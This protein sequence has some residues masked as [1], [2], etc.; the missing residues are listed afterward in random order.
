[1]DTHSL[2][3]DI[4]S[5][6]EK[7]AEYGEV[8][9][10]SKKDY[11][12]AK[13]IRD[14]LRDQGLNARLIPLQVMEWIPGRG[15]IDIGG[16]EIDLTIQ[17][18]VQNAYVEAP[19]VY[20]D[21][22]NVDKSCATIEDSIIITDLPPDVDDINTA[23][24]HLSECGALG[25]IFIDRMEC[26]RRIVCTGIWSPLKGVGKPPSI[27]VLQVPKSKGKE[28][29]RYWGSKT[30]LV[31]EGCKTGESTGYIV[32]AEIPS[33]Y[34]DSECIL[35]TSHHDHWLSGIAD[36][37]VGV[38]MT[39]SISK[40]LITRSQTPKHCVKIVIFTAEE[41]GAPNYSSW[42][43]IY[44]S[45]KYAEENYSYIG[46]VINFD[47]IARGDRVTISATPD[48]AHLM[49]IKAAN[50]GI[51]VNTE[52]DQ[53][54]FDSFSFTMHGISAATLNTFH[55]FLSSGIYHSSLDTIDILNRDTVIKA[56][57]LCISTVEQLALSNDIYGV[58]NPKKWS[59]YVLE[60]LHKVNAPLELI[61]SLYR[62]HRYLEIAKESE[63]IKALMHSLI[64]E[65]IKPIMWNGYRHLG[66]REEILIAPWIIASMKNMW[67]EVVFEG[68]VEPPANIDPK[69]YAA[70]KS[71]I[72][73]KRINEFIE[74]SLLKSSRK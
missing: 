69:K 31:V 24:L 49:S 16:K 52:F 23:Q 28:I 61:D 7:L 40:L 41:S 66:N 59:E 74:R 8:I 33:R 57:A 71:Q 70:L 34:E 15:I 13:T 53:P 27:P 50:L 48:L 12:I 3:K 32:E 20:I 11:E 62:V 35:I 1:M 65:L 67:Y 43:W 30:Y 55:E 9:A 22:N 14:D 42:Y 37:L 38:S 72:V 68:L 6:V 4:I 36:N 58:L 25:V 10:G 5:Y 2:W 45:R 54:I 47:T 29:L 63:D 26:R 73:A 64:S 51:E 18:Y 39:M 56:V 17:P 46:A 44:G 60:N 21:T 19:L